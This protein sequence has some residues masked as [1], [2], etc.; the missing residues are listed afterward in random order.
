MHAPHNTP[1]IFLEGKKTILRPLNK[2]TDI[3]SLVA[4]INDPDIRRFIANYLPFTVSMEE[5]WF[6]SRS[7]DTHHH[8]VL[9]IEAR[10]D[11]KY[12]FIGTMGLHDI[13]WKHRFLITGAMI[14]EKKYWGQGFGT[15]AKM[16]VLDYVFNTL[17]MHKVCSDVISYNK[18][19]LNYS[20]HCGYTVEGVRKKHFFQQGKYYDVI[21][22]GLFKKDWLPIWRAYQ[23]TGRV[24]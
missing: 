4:W 11:N 9:G 7:K 21:E 3:P 19:S 22:L 23:K 2:E 14:G 17:N 24:K 8:I 12:V 6:E 18:R 1:I 20:L 16:T 5:Q 10:V 13:D 15:D